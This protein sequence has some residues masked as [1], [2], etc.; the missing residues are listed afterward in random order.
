VVED[1][2]IISVKYYLSVPVFYLWRK[3]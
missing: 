2:P 1:T 3:L